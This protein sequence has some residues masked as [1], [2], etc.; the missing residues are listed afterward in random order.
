[1]SAIG[2]VLTTHQQA[3]FARI[4]QLEDSIQSLSN[5]MLNVRKE[6][7][8]QTK[9]VAQYLVKAH[10]VQQAATKTLTERVGRLEKV[11]G[12]SYDMDESKSLLNRMD[13]VSFAVEELLERTKDPHASCQFNDSSFFLIVAIPHIFISTGYH[14]I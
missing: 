11:I 13:T 5:E 8:S 3:T 1:M 9:H 4:A 10:S 7:Q 2:P 12:T 14:A 6:A